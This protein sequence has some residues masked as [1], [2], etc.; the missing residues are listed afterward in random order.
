MVDDPGQKDRL[1]AAGDFM[2][3][4]RNAPVAIC[5]VEEPDG[6]EFT[7]LTTVAIFLAHYLLVV[8]PGRRASPA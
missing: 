1:M 4:V 6:Y 7:L 2:T 3:P 5:L 8:R